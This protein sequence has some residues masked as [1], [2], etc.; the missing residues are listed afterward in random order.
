MAN[1][2]TVG[3]WFKLQDNYE[4]ANIQHGTAFNLKSVVTDFDH[5]KSHLKYRISIFFPQK[6]GISLGRSASYMCLQSLRG[7]K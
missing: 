1:Q 2:C 5:A 6:E 4:D 3:C 7:C